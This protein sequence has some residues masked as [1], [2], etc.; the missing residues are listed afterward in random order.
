MR[1]SHVIS[2]WCAD[3]ISCENFPFQTFACI[4]LGVIMLLVVMF[5]LFFEVADNYYKKVTIV[6]AFGLLSAVVTVSTISAWHRYKDILIFNRD[7]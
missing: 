3:L 6:L 1:G 4:Y 5:G 2:T 7:A